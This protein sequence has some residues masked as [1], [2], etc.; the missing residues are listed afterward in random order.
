MKYC[1]TNC[2]SVFLLLHPCQRWWCMRIPTSVYPLGLVM[3][4][5]SHLTFTLYHL[6]CLDCFP[7]SSNPSILLGIIRFSIINKNCIHKINWIH[8]VF[9]KSGVFSH[10]QID[11]DSRHICYNL[12]FIPLSQEVQ[13]VQIFTQ[14]WCQ[15][16]SNVM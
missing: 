12:K 4:L 6:L 1:S 2:T 7:F 14:S 10:V 8:Y 16:K 15:Y 13:N 5:T 3:F 9:N 11:S